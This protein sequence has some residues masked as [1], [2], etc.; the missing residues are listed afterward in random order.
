MPLT[1][2]SLA[3]L[4][5]FTLAL[6]A[7]AES[8]TP[9][10][11]ATYNF[12]PGWKL[13]VGDPAG[14]EAPAFDDA[15]WKSVTL[16]HAW[17]EDEAFQKDIKD[18]ST[19]IAWYRKTFRLPAGAAGQKVFLEF[20]GVRQ[21]GEFFL[22]GK[23]LGRHEN[24]ISACGL[25]V[26]DFV[27]PPP[28]INV[29]AVR[30]DNNWDYREKATNQR[31]QWSDKNF[32]ANYGGLS[33]NVRLHLAD[34]LYQTLPLYSNLGTI[35][36][37]VYAQDFDISRHTATITAESQVR[38]EHPEPRTFGYEV[39][40]ADLDGKVVKKFSGEKLTLAPGATGVAKASA[41]ADGLNFW[42]WGY[43]Y[44]YT[45]TTTLTVDGRAIDSVATRTGF[46]QT[47]FARGMITLNGRVIQ[48]HG[49][50]QRTSNEWPAIGLSVPPWLSDFSNR[51]MVESGGNLVRWMHITPW[52]QDVESCDRVGLIQA[53][54]AGDAEKDATGRQW[55]Q[56]TEVMRDGIIYNRNNPSILFY[57]CGNNGI[58]PD[59]MAQMKAIR[60]QFDPH[61]G[62]AIGSR[63]ML[64]SR[65]AEYGGEMLYINKSARTPFWQ[66]EY[67]RDEGLRKYW[68]DASPPFHQDGDG[69]LYNGQD[70]R[71]YN[72]N[73]DTHAIENVVRWYDY[74]HERPGTGTR[75]NSG[76]VNII[77]SDT[78]THHRG[79]ENY[80][81]SG[82]VDA[83]RLPKDGFFAH[84][85]M[86]D[87]WV[88]IE[89]P[90]L[91]L[92]GHWNYA[93]DTK[94]NLTV[95]SNTER[96]ELFLNDRSLGE[97]KQSSR[98]LFTFEN[99]AW[100]PGTLRAAGLDAAG[101]KVC[102]AELQTAGEPAAL[103]LQSFASPAGLKADGADLALVEVEVIDAQGRRCPTALNLVDFDLS[104]P[105][106]WRGGI[107]QGPDNFI[108]ARSLP[109][110]CG[111]NRVL[112]RPTTV[113]GKITLTAKSTG[114]APAS[115]ALTSQPVA[116][117]DG[118]ATAL[119]A[120]G[121]PSY[122]GR[123][124]TPAGP[125]FNLTRLAVPIA[126]ATAGAHADQAAQSFDDDE[127]TAWANDNQLATG[128]IAYEFARPATPTE[129]TFRLTGWRQRSY[130]IRITLDG[131]E[132]F[133]GPTPKGLGYVTLALQPATGRTLRIELVDTSANKDAFNIVELGNQKENAS[134]GADKI[135]GGTLSI[136]EAEFYEAVPPSPVAAI[137]K[138][139]Q[140]VPADPTL[141]SLFLIGD[142]T[143]RNGFADG[144]GGQW[145][146][147]D[148]LAAFFDAKK[149][150][151]VNRAV[152]GLSSRTFLTLGHWER[153]LTLMKPGDFVIMQFGHNDDWALN[154][155]IPG[156]ALRARG[157]IK[158]TGEETTE[159]DN[160]MTKRHE[161]VHSYGWY[162]RRF[163]ADAR[164]KG[165][166]PI[167][168]SLVPRKKWDAAKII[169]EPYAAWAAEVAAA[170][171]APYL[172][173]NE[174]ISARYEALGA[175]KV[176]P[177]FAD[178]NTHTSL[179]GAE[180]NAASVVAGLKALPDHP[181]NAFLAPK[182][183]A[184]PA[185]TP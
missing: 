113:A 135:G 124:P 59:H 146:W 185:G 81:R 84:Q 90:H 117:T 107:A 43:G 143:V 171:K 70:A 26:T 165:V 62:R 167:V 156:Q 173:L 109:V 21:A 162:L 65:T 111:V 151:V 88:D 5:V 29:L 115:L 68:D 174:I 19:G 44:L 37:Y 166:T 128:W 119:P 169:H 18:L 86:W 69:P 121:V 147:G 130:P 61:G 168:A 105:A 178:A 152:G 122:L 155:E 2:R 39:T 149:I 140:P 183:E 11:R 153:A 80:R 35:G 182:G 20:E 139:P 24:G 36:V 118:L 160:V 184:V 94:K 89:R 83:M 16:P 179:A 150:N 144:A 87:A 6:P 56:R 100:Q 41:R 45:V 110:E 13:F 66:M 40:L 4:I 60:D 125:S 92:I 15:T 22:N 95:V 31:F 97:G 49:Y 177:L 76:G 17:N 170:T 91:H 32:N 74:W 54:P 99:I 148:P 134:T 180:L 114:L 102:E 78:N 72:R 154:D 157:T 136:V 50:A 112:I 77:F 161:V 9:A 53:M 85:V 142:S 145:G 96:V 93:P 10:A 58:A 42:S 46:R 104:G 52:K 116:V 172:P 63:D 7:R 164:A 67:S 120:E 141:P 82:E 127:T 138:H 57:E 12:N 48:M 1:R 181:L 8:P 137:M 131:R 158:G 30:T 108:L 159:I 33:K 163:I 176:E 71:T 75:V 34:R 129:A 132:I 123:G 47:E 73:Q 28:A 79:A 103:R 133:R 175:G 64:G 14:A 38:N 27:L 98:F 101:K 23:P 25:D 106:E 51:L 126:S 3:L 55:E